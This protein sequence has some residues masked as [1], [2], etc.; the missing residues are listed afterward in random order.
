[1]IDF[2]D[3][4]GFTRF[5]LIEERSLSQ[6]PKIKDKT[7]ARDQNQVK[8]P[9]ADLVTRHIKSPHQSE[10]EQILPDKSAVQ[11]APRHVHE[12]T[13]AGI[14]TVNSCPVF[15]KAGA[16]QKTYGLPVWSSIGF[17]RE[18]KSRRH[19]TSGFLLSREG[20][21]G[22]FRTNEV[23]VLKKAPDVSPDEFTAGF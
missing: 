1:M 12:T 8:K 22:A 21:G 19:K 14:G 18:P 7:S 6:I 4:Q 11:N 5:L 16:S 17:V 2:P 10:A 13:F 9:I 20:R 15:T 3:H 23:R